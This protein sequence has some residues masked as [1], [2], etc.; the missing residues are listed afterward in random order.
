MLYVNFIYLYS[1][2]YLQILVTL[3]HYTIP[4]YIFYCH[5]FYYLFITFRN[6]F[7]G[8]FDNQMIIYHFEVVLS[9]HY[10]NCPNLVFLFYHNTLIPVKI[11]ISLRPLKNW[12]YFRG[13]LRK[14]FAFLKKIAVSKMVSLL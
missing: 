7:I 1:C 8:C 10:C 9:I 6:S 4:V 5:N 12:D 14:R 11:I 2:R 13:F 3:F